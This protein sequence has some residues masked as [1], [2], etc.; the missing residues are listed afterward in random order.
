MGG[1]G[2]AG[3]FQYIDHAEESHRVVP[4]DLVVKKADHQLNRQGW[5]SVRYGSPVAPTNFYVIEYPLFVT[6]LVL[7]IF[8]D[9]FAQPLQAQWQ[10]R[11]ARHHQWHGMAH[12]VI[13]LRQKGPVTCQA[14]PAL[15]RITNDRQVE[16]FHALV[17][18]GFLQRV[19]KTHSA[20][21]SEKADS[22]N[23]SR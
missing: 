12:M 11:A 3:A 13:S 6:I 21:S 10:A 17:L 22:V 16:Q 14:D 8:A 7:D 1:Q 9:R 19:K 4:G 20:D 15:K 2:D 18:R 5:A 23:A